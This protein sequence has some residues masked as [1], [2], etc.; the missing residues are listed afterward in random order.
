MLYIFYFNIKKPFNFL[1]KN[2]CFREQFFECLNTIYIRYLDILLIS[3]YVTHFSICHSF[4]D[5]YI[6]GFL[7]DL[8]KVLGYE[9]VNG[10]REGCW[11]DSPGQYDRTLSRTLS[12]TLVRTLV[13]T[14]S[15]TL[16]RTLVRT[17]SRTLVRTLVRTLSRTLSRTI[18][19]INLN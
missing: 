16:V 13:R 2:T 6:L 12:R 19:Q 9:G 15:R 17:L 1:Q 8:G 10:C 4:L 18:H 5:I 14:L 7:T 11:G 3:R